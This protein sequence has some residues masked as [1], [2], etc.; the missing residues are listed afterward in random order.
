MNGAAPDIARVLQVFEQIVDLAAAERAAKLDALC[1]DDASLRAKVEAMLAADENPVDPFAGGAMQWTA[2]LAAADDVPAGRTIDAWRII[3]VAGRGGMGTVYEVE[4]ADGAYQQRAA[5]KLMRAASDSA[6]VRERF[7][8][9]RQMLAQLRHPHIA[10]LLDGG[11][12]PDGDPYFVMEYVQGVPIDRWCDEQRLD[13][14]ARVRLFLQVIEAVGHAHRN[15]LVHRDLKPSN[16]LVDASGH[17]KLLDFGIAKQLQ[18]PELTLLADRAVTFGYASPEQLLDVPI[19]TAT[20]IWQLGIVLHLLLTASHPFG[21]ARDMPLARQLQQLQGDVEPLTRAAAR[22]SLRDCAV[23][24]EF[25]ASALAKRLRGG[26]ATVVS[27]CLRREPTARYHSVDELGT[28]LRRWIDNQ[29]VLAAATDAGERARLWL[30]RNRLLAA[31]VAAVSLALLGGSVLSVWQAREARRESAR[32]RESLQFLADTLGAAAPEQ[33]LNSEVSLRQLLDSAR[34]QLEQRGVIDARVRQPVQRMLGRLY[35]SIGEFQQATQMF[36]AGTKDVQPEGHDGALAL[37]DDLVVYS[38]ALDSLEKNEMAVLVSDQAAA[39]RRRFA[40]HDPEQQLRALAHQ[41]MGHVAKYGW[42]AC[43]QHAAQALAMA[44]AMP[45][46]PVDVVLRLYSDL[47]SVAN[48]TNDR[49]RLLQL[50]EQGLAF[51]DQHGVP[52]DSPQRFTLLR[53]RIEGLLLASRMPEAE[54]AT[55]TAIDLAEKTGGTGTTRL[56]VLYNALSSALVAQGR[57]RE[58]LA[59]RLRAIELLPASDTGHRNLAVVLSSLAG[60][61]AR[62]GDYAASLQQIEQA[63]VQLE[64][65]QLPAADTFRLSIE[66][67]RIEVLLAN[68]RWRQALAMI[69]QQLAVIRDSQGESS[70]DYASALLQQVAALRQAGEAAQGARVLAE[71][72]TRLLHR[73]VTPSQPPFAR[74]LRDE[75]AFARMRADLHTAEHSQREA[76]RRLQDS[77][78]AFEEAVARYELAAILVA[79]GAHHEAAALLA[80]ALPVMQQAVL[81]QQHELRSAMALAAQLKSS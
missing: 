59:Q 56:G 26:L 34:R 13:V 64:Q 7:L 44:L 57:Y 27:S 23:R 1:A 28:D 68:G 70:E 15:L 16:L 63:S 50:S 53:N 10:A 19:T 31:S 9:E 4:R 76:L 8:R 21:V 72:R 42:E 6:A 77:G 43:R 73:G 62:V 11:F 40:P 39:L 79:R 46:P 24:G 17:L 51:A 33:A 36:A 71:A 66:R 49:S 52:A 54:A 65:A 18:D 48:F 37:A 3:A 20:D 5:L 14:R 58:A 55:R 61:Q 2:T 45:H 25:D 81:P 75:A 12:T 41:T 78:N 30:R 35:Y 29:P 47:G 32:A 80:Q 74:L 67:N 38:D 22:A 60:L 69:E